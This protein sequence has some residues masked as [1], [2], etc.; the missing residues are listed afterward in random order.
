MSKYSLSPSSA[1]R[2]VQCPGSRQLES[3]YKTEEQSP[4]AREGT[5]AHWVAAKLLHQELEM[6]PIEPMPSMTP[7]GEP[8][9]EE[10]I[11]GGLLYAKNVTAFFVSLSRERFETLQIETPL[12]IDAIHE[13]CGGTPDV[14]FSVGNN[15]HIFDYKY[16]HK[17]VDAFQNWQLLEY[18]VGVAQRLNIWDSGAFLNIRFTLGIVQPRCFHREGQVRTWAFSGHTLL[19]HFRY[20]KDAE[21]KA[22]QE[23]APTS[24]GNEC[25]GCIARHVCPAL[26]NHALGVLDASQLN[27]PHNLRPQELGRELRYL[28]Q[29]AA[30]L[31]ARITGLEQEATAMIRRGD[32]VPHFALESSRGKQEWKYPTANMIELGKLMGVEL[33]KPA[34]LITPRQALKA[35]LPD[36]LIAAYTEIRHGAMKLTE[37]TDVDILK[38]LRR[39]DG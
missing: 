14:W 3:L 6:A 23:H 13:E 34:A 7:D 39:T 12:T 22:M 32:R 8:I 37:V 33:A 10:M 30:L 2:R 4:A 15:I 35:G 21:E 31:D 36:S 29:A 17:Y 5:A 20:L 19:T 9:T 28:K 25:H 16:G 24:V 26:E 18:A 11:E 1:G 27:I 38:S